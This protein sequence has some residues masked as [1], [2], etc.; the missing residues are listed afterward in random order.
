MLLSYNDLVLREF[1]RDIENGKIC[2][3]N[4]SSD[5]F[6]H[7]SVNELQNAILCDTPVKLMHK[8]R[9]MDRDASMFI[10]TIEGMLSPS[11]NQCVYICNRIDEDYFVPESS[12]ITVKA[13]YD[14]IND[15]TFQRFKRLY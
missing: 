7:F 4:S 14:I 6:V 9:L 10:K 3:V 12:G 1:P 2:I 11:C 8:H 5:A 15:L 13:T